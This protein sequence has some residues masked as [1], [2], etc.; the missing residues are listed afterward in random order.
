MEGPRVPGTP[1]VL[2]SPVIVSDEMFF[3]LGKWHKVNAKTEA[4]I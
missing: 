3:K 1:T 4:T 2:S